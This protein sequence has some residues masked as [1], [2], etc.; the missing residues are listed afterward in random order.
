MAEDPRTASPAPEAEEAGAADPGG[1]ED[2]DSLGPHEGIGHRAAKAPS[3]REHGKKTRQR[4]KD[5]ISG[6]V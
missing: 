5:I 6:R 4:S 1:V 3:D 2:L